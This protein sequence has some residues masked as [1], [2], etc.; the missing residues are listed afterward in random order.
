MK[1]LVLWLTQPRRRRVLQTC[2]G[3]RS[4]FFP[5]FPRQ[6]CLDLHQLD[7]LLSTFPR[8]NYFPCNFGSTP[9]N[10][11]VIIWYNP[12]NCSLEIVGL[13]STSKP[14]RFNSSI[15]SSGM[16]VANENLHLRP[17]LYPSAYSF[18]SRPVKTSPSASSINSMSSNSI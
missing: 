9:Y 6:C 17:Q 15:P 14:A 10:Q 8:F 5:R 18:H 11:K 3:Q 12:L 16:R 7:L 1:S 2:L 4:L 13:T